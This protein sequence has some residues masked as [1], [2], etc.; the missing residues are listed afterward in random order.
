M[1]M[2]LH[3]VFSCRVS[4]APF[5]WLT[6]LAVRADT[7]LLQAA[8]A[9]APL[10]GQGEDCCVK[11]AWRVWRG[12]DGSLWE[13]QQF[14]RQ[15]FLS[16]L[17]GTHCCFLFADTSGRFCDVIRKRLCISLPFSTSFLF[18]LLLH[19]ALETSFLLVIM[20]AKWGLLRSNE[21]KRKLGLKLDGVA[22]KQILR[23]VN[24]LYAMLDKFETCILE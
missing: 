8:G 2:N 24:V 19:S 15:V 5:L 21:M 7:S 23:N 13:E 14:L 16:L 18:P 22:S 17:A 12:E 3:L 6:V 10:L 11:T 20:F 4:G 9:I 1:G